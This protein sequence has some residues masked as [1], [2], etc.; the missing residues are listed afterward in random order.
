MEKFFQFKCDSV[1]RYFTTDV[2][3]TPRY[4]VVFVFG[5]NHRVNL[6]LIY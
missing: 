2:N 4:Y 1:L 5:G 6:M 3:R